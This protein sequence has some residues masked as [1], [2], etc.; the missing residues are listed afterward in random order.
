M[1][2]YIA[3]YESTDLFGQ[4]ALTK[5][6]GGLGTAQNFLQCFQFLHARKGW[7]LSY[8][9]CAVGLMAIIIDNKPYPCRVIYDDREGPN[10]TFKWS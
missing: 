2:G 10:N 5:N 4:V 9:L 8:L 6:E 7:V 1:V 3:G